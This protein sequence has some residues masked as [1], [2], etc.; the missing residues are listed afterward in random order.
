MTKPR[1]VSPL[2]RKQSACLVIEMSHKQE[3]QANMSSTSEFGRE[4]GLVHQIIMN[5][6]RLGADERFWKSLV[7]NPEFL[8]SVI[9]SAKFYLPPRIGFCLTTGGGS[10]D[11]SLLCFSQNEWVSHEEATLRV[12]RFGRFA[13]EDELELLCKKFQ[14][15]W[16]AADC[17]P[18]QYPIVGEYLK[19]H[20]ERLEQHQD[21]FLAITYGENGRPT[22]T[23]CDTKKQREYGGTRGSFHWAPG[24]T[25]MALARFAPV[26]NV[27]ES[28]HR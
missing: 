16:G 10:K 20:Q 8:A 7:G 13:L 26:K 2:A 3:R 22:L 21:Y 9:D 11:F 6:K 5:S 25:F 17:P 23:K 15:L 4:I 24:T 28:R 14:E 12:E 18:L 27:L 19:K 1:L